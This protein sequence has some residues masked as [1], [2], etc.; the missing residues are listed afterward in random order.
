MNVYRNSPKASPGRKSTTLQYLFE[1][2]SKNNN[3]VISSS[4]KTSKHS[5]SESENESILSTISHCSVIF[6]FTDSL[7]S[8]S[9]QDFKRYKLI[10][11]LSTVKSAKKPLP[12]QV[13]SALISMISA[14]LFR[15]LPPSSNSAILTADLPDDE[16]LSYPLSPAWQHLQMV[17]DILLRLVL[18]VDPKI[19]RSYIDESFITNLLYLFQSEDPRE[20]ESLK[21]AYHRI[22]SRFTF[23][24][25]FMRKSMNDV[26]LHY[27][28]ESEKHCGIGE[29]LEIWGSIING[30]TVPLK[31][32]HKLFLMRVLVP[33][34]KTK[35]MQ[36]YHRQLSYCV[37][38]F[39][40]KEP[41]LGG[42]VIRGI[43]RYWPITN[44]QKEFLLIGE[45]EELVENIEP[46]H[47]RKL[48]LPL[49]SQITRCLNSWNSQVAERA[50]YIWNNEQFVKMA[51]SAIKDVFPV[52]VE[53]MEKNLK[54]HWSKSVKQLTE[55][56]KGMLQ[57]M[58]PN[59]YD[60]C[61]QEMVDK[62][63]LARQEEIKRK[64]RWERIELE[65]AKNQFL[66]PQQFLCLSH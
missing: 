65:A 27:V 55:N 16:D 36:V 54:W 48:A 41:M 28:F 53:A 19:L 52:I 4:P 34:H 15:P 24:R 22:Y 9:Q 61:L 42:I 43:L 59:L 44:C 30:F 5:P 23:Y 1:L 60:K 8:P 39:V 11:L 37:N 49:C 63:N 51:S 6:T 10:Q 26:F 33:L 57:E 62:E 38:Q 58:D 3:G 50:L 2:D 18:N 14:N 20:R 64:E 29:L 46:D 66:Q 21:N 40:Q 45:L 17:Y 25:S 12:D 47:Y 13:L 7:E 35:G 56:V 32:E 31:E